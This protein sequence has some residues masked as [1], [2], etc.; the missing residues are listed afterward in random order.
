MSGQESMFRKG[1]T[2][3]SVL[4]AGDVPQDPLLPQLGMLLDGQAMTEVMR[5]AGLA[6]H[7]ARHCEIMQCRVVNVRY[8]PGRQ[9]IVSYALDLGEAGNGRPATGFATAR[10][11]SEASSARRL[12][13]R[14]NAARIAG[15]P[16]VH[17]PEHRM[18]L[19]AFPHDLRVHGIHLAVDPVRLEMVVRRVLA[20]PE[21]TLVA[22]DKRTP[23]IT[24][25]SYRPERFCLVRSTIRRTP[26]A[27][28]EV[29]YARVYRDGK[30][31]HVHET[32]A[33]L[34]NS[35]ARR[36]GLLSVAEPLGYDSDAQTL[37]QS[38]AD[39][40]P[41]GELER[42]ESTLDHIAAVARSLAAIH[43]SSFLVSQV[44]SVEK[45][46][47]WVESMAEGLLRF[48]PDAGERL[49]E[50][51]G[52]LKDAHAATRGNDRCLVHGDFSVNQFLAEPGRVTMLDFDDAGMGDPYT[53]LGTFLARLDGRLQIQ[54]GTLRQ[55]ANDLFRS[56][57]AKT[58]QTVLDENRVLWSQ[59]VAFVRMA[60]SGLGQLK[61]GWP[62]RMSEYLD[63]ADALLDSIRPWSRSAATCRRPEPVGATDQ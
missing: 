40:E 52:R 25:V 3:G 29:I 16:F 14:H 46:L 54:D 36:S 2:R 1:W 60:L 32:M 33:A 63:R 20:A 28:Q 10:I 30:G 12:E 56:E 15:V 39:G 47:A 31:A 6:R 26:N 38:A 4:A 24:V 7:A 27:R 22:T 50:V 48:L 19:T 5:G 61:P 59:A 42:N 58:R 34:W 13:K 9:C 17:L 57:Y 41:L 18:T 11:E 62:D 53:D 49:N 55:Q 35:E 23:P 45:E 44:R 51:V 37:F 8:R 43:G 21:A